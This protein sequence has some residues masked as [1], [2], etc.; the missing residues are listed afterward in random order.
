MTT[1][2][3]HTLQ[4]YIDEVYKYLESSIADAEK[5]AKEHYTDNVDYMRY[6]TAF[7]LGY[8]RGKIKTALSL[9]EDVATK[10]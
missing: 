7:E 6:G 5:T 4:A 8:L 3:N 9:L 10:K 1:K 2:T